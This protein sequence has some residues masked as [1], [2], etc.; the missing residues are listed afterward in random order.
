MVM[1]DAEQ[2]RATFLLVRGQYDQQGEQVTAGVPGFLLR[3]SAGGDVSGRS[4]RL[5]LARWLVEPSHPLTARVTVNRLWQELFGTG[6]V[7]TADDFGVQGDWPSHP[8]LLD[9]L[10]IELIESGWDMKHVLRLIVTSA[11]YQQSSF[12]SAE[13]LARDR[14]NRLL[15]R[16]PG[17]R[18]AAETLRDNALAISGLL[19]E[20]LGGPSVKPYQPPGLWEDVTYDS[21]LAYG[22][23]AGAGLYRRSL[24]TFWKRQSP[25]P[26]MLVFDAPTRETCVVQRSRTNTPLQALVLMND[27]TFIEAARKLAERMMTQAAGPSERI[28]FAFRAATARR[29][30]EDEARILLDVFDRQR[31]DFAETPEE[32]RQLLSVGQSPRDE[33]LDAVELAAWTTVA[34]MILCLHETL[35]R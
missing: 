30:T 14:E 27:P 15:A 16:G 11:T 35:E 2:A 1:R 7:K 12:R 10:A 13:L 26:N 19:V 3:E 6:I 24:Y 20:R 17:F 4:N 22:A 5:E 23:D 32:A 31:A 28:T 9:W 29:P 25:P 21:D 33:S 34:N 8:D 18:M